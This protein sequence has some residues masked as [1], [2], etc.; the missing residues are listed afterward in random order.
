MIRIS[1]KTTFFYKKAFPV[2]WFGV[3][4]VVVAIAL[5]SGAAI[6]DPLF[7]VAPCLMAGIG[8]FLV[9][10][11]LGN[12][13]DEVYDCGDSLLI[14]NR[15]VDDRIALSNI[16]NVSAS[17]NMN[18]PRI[19]LRLVTPG[20]FGPEIAF[21]PVAKFS[22]NPLARNPVAEDLMVRVDQARSSRRR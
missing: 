6:K 18:P 10:K 22:F 7:L 13:A 12:L 15:G 19:T 16:M 14:R 1:S 8:F 3:L 2:L 21:T 17:T 9:K 4:A 11:L 5:A 20:K